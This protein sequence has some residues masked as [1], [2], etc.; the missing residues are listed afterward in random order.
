MGNTQAQKPFHSVSDARLEDVRVEASNQSIGDNDQYTGD[1]DFE[2][3]AQMMEDGGYE[4]PDMLRKAKNP[5]RADYQANSCSQT[6][7]DK[8]GGRFKGGRCNDNGTTQD[9]RENH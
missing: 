7:Q 1:A 5:G 2:T 4:S 3:G 8:K 6:P 9:R